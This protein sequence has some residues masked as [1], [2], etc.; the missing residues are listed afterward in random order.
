VPILQN[1][2][3]YLATYQH[4]GQGRVGFQLLQETYRLSLEGDSIGYS[5]LWSK[6]IEQ[7]AR[8][9]H[10]G[11]EIRTEERFPIFTDEP[12]R[13]SVLSP[14]AAPTL[15][16]E[17]TSLPLSEDIFID[18]LWH[19]KFWAGAPGWLWLKTEQDSVAYYVS[20]KNAWPSLVAASDLSETKLKSRQGSPKEI[21][22]ETE[23][24]VPVWIFFV[25]LLVS[26][27]FLWLAPKV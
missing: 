15:T 4:A 18:D 22:H 26:L 20:E 21:S 16:M 8:T 13:V 2:N 23:R 25:L 3:R 24:P 1:K 7:V 17:R 19:G 9:Q 27:G 10:R 12:V 14:I 11:A 6:C 5:A